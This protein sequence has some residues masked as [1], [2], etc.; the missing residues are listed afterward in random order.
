MSNNTLSSNMSIGISGLTDGPM[1]QTQKGYYENGLVDCKMILT[2]NKR[3][4]Q[5][6]QGEAGD[7]RGHWR[8]LAPAAARRISGLAFCAGLCAPK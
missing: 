3:S 5:R 8:R 2:I 1:I 7:P 6:P 4:I